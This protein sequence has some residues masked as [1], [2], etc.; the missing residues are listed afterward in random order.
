MRGTP[1]V[2]NFFASTCIPCITEMPAFEEVYQEVEGQRARWRSSGS[3]SPT[4]P[5]TPWRSSSATGVTYPT[6]EDKD[7]SVISALG[8]TLLPTTV[9]LDAD[10]EIVVAPRRASSPPT[11]CER[12]S[13]TTSA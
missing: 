2:V 6:A 8:G 5:T 4:A 13:P 9:L 1:T 3:P 11:S 12:C 10:G 7:A